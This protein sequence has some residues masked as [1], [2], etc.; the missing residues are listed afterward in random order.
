MLS[1]A[2]AVQQ[3]IV[4]HQQGRIDLAEP[5]YRQALSIDPNHPDALHLLGLIALQCEQFAA[6]FQLIQAAIQQRPN[7]AIY[8]G[9]LGVAFEKQGDLQ[10]AE[11]A[12]RRALELNPNYSDGFNNLGQILQRSGRYDEATRLLTR[13]LEIKPE[14]ADAWNNL[15]V[16]A[17][18]HFQYELAGSHLLKALSFQPNHVSARCNLGTVHL[19]LNEYELASEQFLLALKHEPNSHLAHHG[20]ATVQLKRG[21]PEQAIAGFEKALAL[22]PNHAET[23]IHL[24]CA[25]DELDHSVAAIEALNRAIE[26]MPNS[27]DAYFNLGRVLSR[28]EQYAQA[29]VAIDRSLELRPDNAEA[30]SILVNQLQNLCCWERVETISQ[31]LIAKVAN[32]T[33]EKTYAPS[34]LVNPSSFV[35]LPEPTNWELQYQCARAWVMNKAPS[36][37]KP[38]FPISP[39]VS[40][41]IRARVRKHPRIRI[42]YLSADFRAHVMASHM[43][44]LFEKHERKKFEVHGYSI[45]PNDRSSIRN[46]IEQAFDR[47]EDCVTMA[48][49]AIAEKIVHDEIDILVDLQG[50]T[51]LSRPEI[52][53]SKPAPIQISYLGFACTTGA[54]YIDYVLV[55]EFVAPAEMQPYFTERLIQLPGCYQVN[56][57]KIENLARVPSREECALQEESFVFCAFN[58]LFKIAPKMFEV[59]MRILKSVDRSVLWIPSH[60]PAAVENLR[61]EAALRGIQ[62]ERLVFAPRISLAEHRARHQLANLFLDTFP[63][64]AHGTAAISLQAGVP[65]VTMKGD[66]MASRVAGSLLREV[67]LRDLIAS[68]YEQ[69]EEIA[70]RLA[71]NPAELE[72]IR[73]TLAKGIESSRL[74]KCETFARNVERAYEVVFNRFLA[75]DPPRGFRL[76]NNGETT[77][78]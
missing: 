1:T 42:G 24:G 43:V 63:Y 7:E 77:M 71:T 31:S 40:Q 66:T 36:S 25:L 45:G 29:V 46:R 12:F 10:Q 57:S 53:A 70:V 35:V 59:W 44:E 58:A 8:Y 38:W 52:F 41:P 22:H 50:H 21:K 30:L 37:E 76:E 23:W 34:V 62:E 13:A 4:H 75:G 17:M 54:E 56:Q 9:N 65:I 51:L 64:N 72:R 49:E 16:G 19:A 18:K 3:G 73:N 20:L 32:S 60:V 6:A 5:L 74:F 27:P 28:S 33:L 14:N 78:L 2:E 47:F 61:R 11:A 48:P 69:Y 55:D 39:S 67:G 68:N 26:L 15:G